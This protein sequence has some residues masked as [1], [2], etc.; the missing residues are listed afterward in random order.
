MLGV[1]SRAT[2]KE[3]SA[4]EEVHGVVEFLHIVVSNRF[5]SQTLSF[6]WKVLLWLMFC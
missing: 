3:L 5:N 4:A 6:F 2:T 1:P